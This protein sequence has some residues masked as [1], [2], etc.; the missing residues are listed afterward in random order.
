M[1]GALI[2]AW[3]IRQSTIVSR[4][5]ADPI[6]AELRVRPTVHAIIRRLMP[7]RAASHG[8]VGVLIAPA[9]MLAVT[10]Q[11]IWSRLADKSP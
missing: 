3:Q 4:L 5:S 9:T 1:M 6:R 11:E 2:A 8:V 10:I 7:N